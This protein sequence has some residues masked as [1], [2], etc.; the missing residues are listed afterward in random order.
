MRYIIHVLYSYLL[1][2]RVYCLSVAEVWE[3]N[4]KRKND[5]E[6]IPQTTENSGRNWY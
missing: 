4:G 1:T 3:N 6:L 2:E 5:N